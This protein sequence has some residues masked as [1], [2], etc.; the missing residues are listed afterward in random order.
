MNIFVLDIN[1][2]YAA[3]YHCDKHVVKMVLET[4]QIMCS[5][6]HNVSDGMIKTPYRPTHKNHPC[7][8]WAQVSPQNFDWL[9]RLGIALGDEYTHRYGKVHK[10]VSVIQWCKENQVTNLLYGLTPFAQAMPEEYRDRDPV[11]AYRDYYCKDKLLNI[12]CTWTKR[13]I[14][15]WVM[16]FQFSTK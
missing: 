12:K 10:S 15:E 4:A 14:P 7:V 13:N 1:P 8:Q 11:K 2:I 16:N 5:A 3:R 9:Y 6:I